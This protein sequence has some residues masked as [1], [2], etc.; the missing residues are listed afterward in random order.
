M[1]REIH[2]AQ[3]ATFAAEPQ[4]MNDL[5]ALNFVFGANGSGKTTISRVIADP[6]RYDKCKLVWEG[7]RELERLVYN[8]DFV[9]KNFASTM[10]GIFTLGE[11]EVETLNTIR[12][13]KETIDA[14]EHDLAALRASLGPLD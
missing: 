5:R 13:T 1:L 14:L 3:K 6:D 8:T 4:V 2:I 7:G 12:Q 11:A 10:P 9:T